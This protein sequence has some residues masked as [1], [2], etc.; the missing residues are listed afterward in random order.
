[1]PYRFSSAATRAA[2]APSCSSRLARLAMPV[3][4][5][6]EGDLDRPLVARD[7]D[8]FAHLAASRLAC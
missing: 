5:L 7:L 3:G 2:T 1:M 8:A 4:D 6:A